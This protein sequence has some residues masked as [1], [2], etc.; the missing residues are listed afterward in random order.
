M[1]NVTDEAVLLTE[2]GAMR[3]V[4]SAQELIA[5]VGSMISE[6]AVMSKMGQVGKQVVFDNKEVLQNY[7]QAILPFIAAK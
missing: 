4:N 2:A 3:Q 7:V 5:E 1:E 6:P